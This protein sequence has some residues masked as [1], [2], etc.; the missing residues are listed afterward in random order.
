MSNNTWFDDDV[1][2]SAR[3]GGASFLERGGNFMFINGLETE[4]RLEYIFPSS[5]GVM[6][7][8]F[9]GR[10]MDKVEDVNPFRRIKKIVP[11]TEMVENSFA[12]DPMWKF[13]TVNF[14]GPK[15]EEG[16]FGTRLHLMDDFTPEQKRWYKG[17]NMPLPL[18]FCEILYNRAP[19]VVRRESR[20]EQFWQPKNFKDNCVPMPQYKYFSLCVCVEHTKL[21]CSEEQM[22]PC[23]LS[24][25]QS[26]FN[27]L[28]GAVME[29]RSGYTLPR[30]ADHEY[31]LDKK[32]LKE[33]FIAP[34]LA[35]CDD[36]VLVSFKY[37]DQKKAVKSAIGKRRQ[38]D[39]MGCYYEA[40]LG[41][42]PFPIDF[43]VCKTYYKDPSE[44]FRFMTPEE[45]R[46]FVLSKAPS[47][48]WEDFIYKCLEYTPLAVANVNPSVEIKEVKQEEVEDE[49]VDNEEND[50]GI[51]EGAPFDTTDVVS[52][53]VAAPREESEKVE[54]KSMS[55]IK[56]VV[57]E[58][59]EEAPKSTAEKLKKFMKFKKPV[60]E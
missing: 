12:L 9:L 33:R 3:S 43:D 21:D 56:K 5:E 55:A 16:D 29:E 41:T 14:L 15:P 39:R 57:R 58:E 1:Q 25:Q 24:L 44:I 37:H 11:I 10:P 42:K 54:K 35:D 48:D 8:R 45:Q 31:F 34:D 30:G 6:R 2:S 52:D 50:A 46:D 17:K 40:S 7:V 20:F 59:E 19:D 38:N 47:K 32:H 36:G 27:S 51:Q 28:F 53:I 18:T 26:A 13:R 23:L 60:D 22:V 4:P 49:E